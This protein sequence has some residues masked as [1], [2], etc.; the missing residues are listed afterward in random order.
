MIN[1]VAPDHEQLHEVE[2]FIR[3]RVQIKQGSSNAI[4]DGVTGLNSDQSKFD[5]QLDQF[6]LVAEPSL[7][8]SKSQL[9]HV[10]SD[11]QTNRLESNISVESEKKSV[12]NDSADLRSLNPR[13]LNAEHEQTPQSRMDFKPDNLSGVYSSRRFIKLKKSISKSQGSTEIFGAFCA[14]NLPNTLNN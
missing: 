8:K 7:E 2:A 4:H 6:K 11:Y 9:D 10:E 13:S 12:T 14:T 1:A 5:Q 3:K